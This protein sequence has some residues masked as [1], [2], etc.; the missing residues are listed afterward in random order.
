[1]STSLIEDY[2]ESLL[3]LLVSGE[4][5]GPLATAPAVETDWPL[6]AEVA[7]RNVALLQC[8]DRLQ[9]LD[10]PL[11]PA[12]QEAVNRERQRV[13]S[14]LGVVRKVNGVC[15]QTRTP[16]VFTKSFQH[17]PDTG[18][19]IDLLIPDRSLALDEAVMRD[20]NA[21]RVDLD[22]GTRMGGKTAYQVDNCPSHL[23]IHHGREGFLGE[24]GP[25][26]GRLIARRQRAEIA[27]M[28]TFV[29]S[30]EDHLLLQVVQRIYSK[31]L[32]R[33]S[34]AARTVVI[35]GH[36]HLDWTYVEETSRSMGIYDGLRCYLSLIDQIHRP[37]FGR[38]PLPPEV[39][40]GLREGGGVR[41]HFSKWH[42]RFPVV[43]VVPAL[44]WRVG[45]A[46][47]RAGQWEGLGRLALLPVFA[48]RMG[49]RAMRG[50]AFRTK[51]P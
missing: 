37:L 35:L 41:V 21:L 28:S 24:H 16:F 43:P 9:E 44:Y 40:D 22:L 42:Y 17:Y 45:M 1:M 39:S 49:L 18:R 6:L 26:A 30:P 46:Q 7:E 47:V 20:L 36:E 15:L 14:T 33:L 10:I 4:A 34:D 51:A 3:R 32:I 29:P 31:C 12:F 13:E 25:F 27:G 19:D 23:E 48:F 38:S 5:V 2:A 8:S 11:G 50:P